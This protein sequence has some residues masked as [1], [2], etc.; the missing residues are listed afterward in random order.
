[1]SNAKLIAL[2]KEMS[3]LSLQRY[4]DLPASMLIEKHDPETIDRVVGFPLPDPLKTF[5]C[6]AMLV[7]ESCNAVRL[8]QPSEITLYG[9]VSN[10]QAL[11]YSPPMKIEAGINAPVRFGRN[12]IVF[13]PDSDGVHC[14]DVDP[15]VATGGTLHQIVYVSLHKGLAKV[16]FPS[17]EAFLEN[18]IKSI[19]RGIKRDLAYEKKRAK[20]DEMTPERIAEAEAMLRD[21]MAYW[22]KTM[23]VLRAAVNSAQ[24]QPA[25]QPL[26]DVGR[27]ELATKLV[28][29]N[30]QSTPLQRACAELI[31]C[32]ARNPEGEYECAVEDTLPPMPL[33]R[34]SKIEKALSVKL[35]P[36]LHDLLDAHQRIGIPW[37]NV[38]SLGI[39][40][41]IVARCR[42]LRSIKMPSDGWGLWPGTAVPVFG[43][44]LLHLGGD[45][46]P[47]ICYDLAPG[48][49]GT[50]G[51]LVE[52]SFEEVTCKVIAKSLLEFLS[53]GLE[54]V[55][56]GSV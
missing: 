1:M 15:N 27:R 44:G 50:V 39:D 28:A 23:E 53:Q 48:I 32:Y 17:L 9:E 6:T 10:D 11:H 40:D 13:G 34:R 45:G 20:Q 55:K 41:D 56:R 4:P 29:S 21:P 2:V 18:G 22:Q 7:T 51:Q 30:P 16:V 37:D 42:D 43:K 52:V 33:A 3:K 25:V 46:D 35:P 19:K 5:Y 38:V 12:L 24:A 49:A 14:I 54:A 8:C 31:E 36:D 47:V 26:T